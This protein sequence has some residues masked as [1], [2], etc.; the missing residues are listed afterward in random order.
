V[1]APVIGARSLRQLEDNLGAL[2]V[3]LDAAQTAELEKASPLE[4]GFPHDF[5]RSDFIRAA[6]TGG[7]SV[8]DRRA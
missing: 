5:L 3:T 1:T 8:R 6:W 2:S 7:T 4:L